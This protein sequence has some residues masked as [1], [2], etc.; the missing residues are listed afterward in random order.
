[1]SDLGHVGGRRGFTLI[2]LLV[3]IAIIAVLIA[4]L[5]PAVQQAREAARRTQCRNNLHQIG[6][7]L[8]NYHDTHGT[9]PQGI[10]ARA[11]STGACY[12]GSTHAS[13]CPQGVGQS[14]PWLTLLLPFVD[15]TAL[16]N[17][18]N[19]DLNCVSL[20]NSTAAGA[21]LSQYACPSNTT[22]FL[23][24]YGGVS[25]G[26]TDYVGSAGTKASGLYA[27]A[28]TCPEMGVPVAGSGML[29]WR[30]NVRI[31][32]VRDGTSNTFI[33]GEAWANT[34]QSGATGFANAWHYGE[35]VIRSTC[36]DSPLNA[37]PTCSYCFRS[38]HEGG[39]FFAMADGQVRFVSENIDTTVYGALGTR[40][41]NELIDDEDF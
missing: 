21:M 18:Y 17:A 16:Y 32:D 9:F 38:Q 41:G 10:A 20:A 1:M 37:S 29:F 2:E 14:T 31:R 8:H 28:Y 5:L 40:A 6:L 12:Q 35:S 30:N 11:H 34:A 7:A 4:L 33:A 19:M 36:A 13:F 27:V 24:S 26:S 25:F 23:H 39:A 22:P 15:E 3:V